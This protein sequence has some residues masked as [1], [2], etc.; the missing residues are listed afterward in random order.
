MAFDSF[1]AGGAVLGHIGVRQAWPDGIVACFD[2]REPGG[3]DWKA[4]HGMEVVD[5]G[6]NAW[7]VPSIESCG[8][9]GRKLL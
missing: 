9:R 8:A 2:C 1:C 3:F 5:K 6:S 4:C 7:E